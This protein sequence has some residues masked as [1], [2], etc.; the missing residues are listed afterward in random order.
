MQVVNNLNEKFFS[1]MIQKMKEQMA[2]VIVD[3]SQQHPDWVSTFN[4]WSFDD[5]NIVQHGELTSSI[6]DFLETFNKFA[7][8]QAVNTTGVSN[9]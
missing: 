4:L 2:E 3:I 5:V 7:E 8:D 6:S 9:F 1:S